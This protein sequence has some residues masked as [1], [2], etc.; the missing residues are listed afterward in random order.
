MGLVLRGGPAG[1]K[2]D[3]SA[4]DRGCRQ[5]LGHGAACSTLAHAEAADRARLKQAH[6]APWH[7][8]SQHRP[9]VDSNASLVAPSP[10]QGVPLPA[11][12][13]RQLDEAR[14]KVLG[15]QRR[16]VLVHHAA[17]LKVLVEKV[18]H[19]A[20]RLGH[21]LQKVALGDLLVGACTC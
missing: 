16:Q 19:H 2:F 8:S 15:R 9:L 1:S 5:G 12:R 7:S 10:S 14:A 3:H 11:H 4:S 13:R 20:L 17:P 6:G 21:R 18:A